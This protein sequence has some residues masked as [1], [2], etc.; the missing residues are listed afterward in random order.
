MSIKTGFLFL[1][2]AYVLWVYCADDILQVI[3]SGERSY[4]HF[5]LPISLMC[6]VYLLQSFVLRP[7][8]QD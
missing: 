7:T 3:K 6:S 1:I 5:V 4:T 2:I 8:K